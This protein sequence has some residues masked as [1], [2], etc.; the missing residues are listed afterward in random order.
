MRRFTRFVAMLAT[1]L[2]AFVIS[3]CGSNGGDG[4]TG[5]ITPPPV[6]TV[7]S[8]VASCETT[9]LVGTGTKTTCKATAYKSN[10][11]S[12]DAT[13]DATWTS[14]AP[15]VAVV[16]AGVVT[17]VSVG[18]SQV[19]AAF[20]GVTSIALRVDVQLDAITIAYNQ[21]SAEVQRMVQFFM[22]SN[23]ALWRP[24]ISQ[25]LI[26]YVDPN[27][28]AAN[29]ATALQDWKN[30]IGVNFTPVADSTAPFK[31][32]Y[33]HNLTINGFD[34]CGLGGISDGVDGVATAGRARI[35]SDLPQCWGWVTIA[36]EIGHM[37][38]SGFHAPEG[39]DIMSGAG[40]DK[41]NPDQ[42]AAFQFVFHVAPPGWKVPT[43]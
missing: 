15:S 32:Y 24:D 42:T 23:R 22:A 8:V 5:I 14:S 18:S 2:V 4:P 41:W 6:V 19:T 7:T 17:A 35:N 34:A 26:L 12:V 39:T 38:G 29:V 20:G 16:T 31:L 37:L 25:P 3:A 21:L 40:I 43:P 11:T 30:R 36:H 27:L 10:N 9:V 1:V 28:P 13:A 33:E